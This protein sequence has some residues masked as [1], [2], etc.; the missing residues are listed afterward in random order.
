MDG[1][2]DKNFDPTNVGKHVCASEFNKESFLIDLDFN[3]NE[4]TQEDLFYDIYGTE[5]EEAEICQT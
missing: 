4:T 1:I 5:I 2:F 3:C